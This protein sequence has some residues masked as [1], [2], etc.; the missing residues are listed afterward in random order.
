ME[1]LTREIGNRLKEERKRLQIEH[2]RDASPAAKLVKLGDKIVNVVDVTNQ[3]PPI[4]P[5]IVS[6]KTQP[7][8]LSALTCIMEGS[9]KG[10]ADALWGSNRL[11]IPIGS[12]RKIQNRLM[13][14]IVLS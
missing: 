9:P 1:S 14:G 5:T 4:Q 13:L 2:A 8:K 7:G 6:R 11:E 3:P 10:V 12:V